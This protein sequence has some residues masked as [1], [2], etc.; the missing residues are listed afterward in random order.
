VTSLLLHVT[1]R[2]RI[3]DDLSDAKVIVVPRVLVAHPSADVY[4]SDLQLL[5]SIVGLGEAGWSSVLCLPERGPLI[6]ATG[7]PVEILPTPVLRKALLRP[8]P[9]L[10][11]LARLPVDLVRVLRL[12]R[13]V[14]PDVVY[15]NTVTIP[16]W[17]VAARLTRR[18][19][20]VHV[21]EAEQDVPR[22]LRVALNLPLLLA[23]RVVANSRAS[24]DV[25]T[26]AVPR[27]AAR[28]TVV[29]NGV[30]DAGVAPDESEAG[31]LVLVAR[32]SP[33]KGIDVALEAVA[34][35]RAEGRAVRLEV[36]GTIFPGYE[37]YEQQL[38]DRAAEPDLAGTVT[39]AGYVRPTLPALARAAVV[40]VPSRVEPFGN[41][42]VEAL[43][44]Q[45]PLVASAVQGL[46]EIVVD[47]ETGLLVPPDDPVAL[48]AAIG[49][50]LDDPEAAA[51]I[52]VR[53]RADAVERF[54]VI[55]Y[56]E[57][58]ARAVAGLKTY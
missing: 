44:S 31:R 48:A 27:L 19:V 39:F 9:L 47:G 21:H 46:A 54:S 5:E 29:L 8:L 50:L 4:G 52:A 55:R 14:R 10:R 32:L 22:A 30:P 40:L 34:L 16:L 33:R 18:P 26:S 2:T 53:G 43:L 15:V 45:R 35:L 11:M 23:H 6:E 17:I 1:V 37:W 20:L 56:R 51:S 24:A 12:L 57:D 3:G 36:C 58:I 42:A 28:T 41:T 13:R 7:S 38:R 25:A 49:R